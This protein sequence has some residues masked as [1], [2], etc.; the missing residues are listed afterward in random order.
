MS[1]RWSDGSLTESTVGLLDKEPASRRGSGVF[2]PNPNDQKSSAIRRYLSHTGV[3]RLL[4]Y[5]AALIAI[6]LLALALPSR[7]LAPHIRNVREAIGRVGSSKTKGVTIVSA[8]YVVSDGKKHSL[9][10]ASANGQQRLCSLLCSDYWYW[11]K[12]FLD[13]VE[14]PIVFYTS[15]DL[16]D[17]VV[18][19]RGNKPITVVAEF[20]TASQMPPIQVLGGRTWEEQMN[21]IDDQK[22]IHVP[23]VYGPWTAKPWML[24]HA[25]EKNFYGSK[26]FFWVR[27]AS[28]GSGGI[29]IAHPD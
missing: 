19:L 21:A 4:I 29:Y 28:L 14:Q 11:M 10:G 1:N 15:P 12:V 7:Q 27:P 5:A 17:Q 13:N 16:V 8:F 9:D 25:A 6:L 24:K 26:Y 22:D 20:E 3:R 2:S 18:A 23:G